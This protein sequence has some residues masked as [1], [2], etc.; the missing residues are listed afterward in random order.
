MNF[1]RRLMLALVIGTLA[2][3]GFARA[4]AQSEL[5]PALII[6]GDTVSAHDWKKTSALISEILGKTG[7]IKVDITTT[8]GKDLTDENL[9]K[10]KLLILNYFNT[11][12]GAPETRWSDAN[13]EAFLKAVK[14][15]AGLVVFH[16]ASGAF[17]RPNWE[18]FEKV[19]AGGWRTQ[20][21]HGPRHVFKVKKSDARHPISEGLPAEFEHAI[22]ELYQNSMITPGSVV[23]ATAYSDPAKPKGTG[24]DE[25]VVWVNSYGKGRVYEITLGHDAEAIADTNFQAWLTRGSLWAAGGLE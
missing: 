19:V 25:P 4:G 20:G 5:I 17:A 11:A 7:K 22:D 2:I 9:A 14:N 1:E 10:Y 16:H 21:F 23:L 13:K 3:G 6:T 12:Q 18:E 24:K 8:P 15:G